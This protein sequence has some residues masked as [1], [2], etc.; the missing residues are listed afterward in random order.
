VTNGFVQAVLP[1]DLPNAYE[2]ARVLAIL[3]VDQAVLTCAY[4]GDKAQHWDHLHAYVR[5]KRPS[6]YF[7]E[8]RNLVPACGPC[9]TSKSGS[10]WR[11]WMFG[12]AKGSPLS[13]GVSDLER[14]ATLLD[15]LI[16]ELELQP[17]NVESLI[18][19]ELWDEYWQQQSEIERMMRV[20]QGLAEKIKGQ[21]K[22][23]LM[24]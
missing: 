19:P 12:R 13:R 23:A 10:H 8:A 6:G 5:G 15:Q 3:G 17:V 22:L 11:E 18:S 14:R 9:N 20:A 4:C 1:D 24:P 2:H 7:N 16:V 21:L